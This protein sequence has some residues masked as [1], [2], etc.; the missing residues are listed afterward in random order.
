MTAVLVTGMSGTGKSTVM[1]ELA[2][3]GHRVVDTDYGDWCEDVPHPERGSEQLWREDRIG[4]LLAEPVDGALFV[5]GT[6]A[7]QG[8]FY[9]RFDA[10]VLLSVPE[11]VLLRPASASRRTNDY[12]KTDAERRLLV[13]SDLSRGRAAARRVRGDREIDTRRPVDEVADLLESIAGVPRAPTHE[14]GEPGFVPDGV[15]VGIR[16]SERA[17]I[18][19]ELDRRSQVLDRI[20]RPPG[21]ALAARDVV[22]EPGVVRIGRDQ[23]AATVSHLGVPPAS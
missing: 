15:E 5:S 18:A 6:V 19:M 11:D 22:Q 2:R 10:I 4:A 12:G 7:N 21:Q 23:L 13:L 8:R 9:P 14:L 3:R 16:G 17:Q 20:G 1:A